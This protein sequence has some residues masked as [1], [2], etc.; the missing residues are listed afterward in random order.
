MSVYIMTT[1]FYWAG[2]Q[3]EDTVLSLC[4][5]NSQNTDITFMLALHNSCQCFGVN[6]S[7]AKQTIFQK[8]NKAT[9]E[10]YYTKGTQNESKRGFCSLKPPKRWEYSL[11]NI[12]SDL[13]LQYKSR[14][15]ALFYF[16]Q[17]PYLEAVGDFDSTFFFR[18]KTFSSLKKTKRRGHMIS[19]RLVL[20]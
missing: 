19:D 18:K 13:Y 8:R 15:K 1:Y 4:C 2:S 10:G 6:N 11:I 17:P 3:K 9:V 16:L 20:S 12:H 5:T 7:S 14:R